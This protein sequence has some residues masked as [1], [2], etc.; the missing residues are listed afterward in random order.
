MITMVKKPTTLLQCIAIAA[1]KIP[2]PAPEFV[3][4]ATMAP[5]EM[6]SWQMVSTP[7]NTLTVKEDLSGTLCGA[8]FVEILWKI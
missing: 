6:A 4:D 5:A 2:F 3:R 7:H 1:S 8:T